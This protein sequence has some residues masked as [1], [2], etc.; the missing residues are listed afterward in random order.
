MSSSE[1]GVFFLR[2]TQPTWVKCKK[3]LGKGF[4]I[5][6]FP[7]KMGCT[8]DTSGEVIS[9]LTALSIH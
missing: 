5:F 2:I 3:F 7:E 1:I 9:E 4:K 6:S 8:E